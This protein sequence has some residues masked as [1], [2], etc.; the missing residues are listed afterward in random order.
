L[1]N[2][3]KEKYS[4][5]ELIALYKGSRDMQLISKLYDKYSLKIY[6]RCISILKDEQSAQDAVHDIFIKIL[7]NI[8]KFSGKSRFSTWLYSITYNYC[9]DQIRKR[10]KLNISDDDVQNIELL[11]EPNNALLLEIKVT[12]LE[13]ILEL[14]PKED[15]T[16]L[17]MKY[18]DGMTIREISSVFD[19]TESSIKMK[20]KRAK[21]KCNIQ[22]CFLSCNFNISYVKK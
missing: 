10:K 3:I 15:K 19:K 8:Y 20:L 13:K 5:E 2:S 7:L 18:Q 1:G 6:C 12:R 4:D 16:I 17:L 9:I 14:I 21:L 11:D 22:N